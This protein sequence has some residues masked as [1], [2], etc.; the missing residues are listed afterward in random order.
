[1]RAGRLKLLPN[2]RL[3]L[4]APGFRMNSVCARANSVVVSIDVAPAEVGAAA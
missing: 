3:K 1:M 2:K 4:A